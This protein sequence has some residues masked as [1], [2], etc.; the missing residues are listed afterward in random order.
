MIISKSHFSIRW[1]HKIASSHYLSAGYVSFISHVSSHMTTQQATE[2]KFSWL[3]TLMF[4]TD[5]L[6]PPSSLLAKL[7]FY[8]ECQ[9][10]QQKYNVLDSFVAGSNFVSQ[11]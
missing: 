7:E 9:H 10:I 8:S 3:Q 4:P 1:Y 11:L 2:V 5:Y 6:F